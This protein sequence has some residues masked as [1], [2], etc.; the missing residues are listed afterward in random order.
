MNILQQIAYAL[1]QECEALY[2]GELAAVTGYTKEQIY[3]VLITLIL[4]GYV[5]EQTG[6]KKNRYFLNG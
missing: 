6:F 1:K 5:N 4:M 3:E 2:L